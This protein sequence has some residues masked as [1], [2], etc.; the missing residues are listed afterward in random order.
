MTQYWSIDRTFGIVFQQIHLQ[1]IINT[2]CDARYNETGGIIIGQYTD[3]L[4]CAI[5][6][7]LL[8]PTTD[9]KSGRTWLIR[10]TKGLRKI[11]D[12]HWKEEREYYIGEWHF[13]PF[14]SPNPSSQDLSQMREIASS[15][16]YKCPEPILII[17]GGNPAKELQLRVFVFPK[18]ELV[19]LLRCA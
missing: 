11:I 19:E 1:Q 4:S 8:G 18:G 5:I 10:G 6:T 16:T 15:S 7:R 17:A 14:A 13:H 2:C 3:S 12:K 9:S